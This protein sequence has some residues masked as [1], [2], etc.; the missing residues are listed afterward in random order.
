[1][2]N[3]VCAESILILRRELRSSTDRTGAHKKQSLQYSIEMPSCHEEGIFFARAGSFRVSAAGY[4][5]RVVRRRSPADGP[6]ALCVRNLRRLASRFLKS[7]TNGPRKRKNIHKNQWDK[8][9]IQLA[10][11]LHNRSAAA[12]ARQLKYGDNDVRFP[13]PVF[14]NSSSCRGPM[15]CTG[16]TF[17][18]THDAQRG[19]PLAHPHRRNHRE[20]TL[21]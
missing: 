4:P 8:I 14:L 17:T 11:T 12:M 1:M 5:Q 15:P 18:R 19:R 6:E 10:S 7:R 16:D 20:E 13:F 2:V 21:L 3:G 9:F